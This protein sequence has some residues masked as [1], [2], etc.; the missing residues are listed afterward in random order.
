MRNP[1]ALAL[2][3]SFRKIP[4]VEPEIYQFQSFTWSGFDTVVTGRNGGISPLP[5][6]SLNLSANV[7]DSA[8][9]VAGNFSR[10][11]E[12]TDITEIWNPRQVHGDN[13]VIINSITPANS[14]KGDAVITNLKGLY[15]GVLTADCLPILLA[16]PERQVVAAIHA[17]RRGCE[18]L[19][20]AKVVNIMIKNFNCNPS[21]I[22]A[23]LGPCI[24][25]CCYEV[26]AATASKFSKNCG[27]T[28]GKYLDIVA[29]SLGQLLSCGVN[30]KNVFDCSVCTSCDNAS[31]FSH[32]KDRNKTGR[33]LSAIAVR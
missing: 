4:A 2:I 17:G 12:A 23:A 30:S 20:A 21:K 10:V 3:E 8:K 24:R 29:A 11:M 33:F 7:G 27:C 28:D 26:D 1:K 9:N 16:E 15:T 25:N 31:F 19:I 5:F 13:V 22:L 18:K 32:R 14:L 6:N